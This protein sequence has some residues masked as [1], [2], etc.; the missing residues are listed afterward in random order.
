MASYAQLVQLVE[1]PYW[2]RAC[3]KTVPREWEGEVEASM[4]K[5]L[6]SSL[7]S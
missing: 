1:E 2:C 5:T 7:P 3:K 6:V 4:A